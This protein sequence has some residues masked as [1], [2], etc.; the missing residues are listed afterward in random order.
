MAKLSI[1]PYQPDNAEELYEAARESVAE[2]QPFLPWCHPDY[3]IDEARSWI[4]LQVDQFKSGNEYQF[5]IVSN[6]GKFLGGCGLNGIDRENRRANLGYWIRST[7]T[8]RG[9]ATAATRLLA[10]WAFKNTDLNRLEIIVSTMNVASLGV[11]ERAGAVR[12]GTLR[13]RLMLHGVAH[14]AV[15]FSYIR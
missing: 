9:A 1:R 7:E 5:V 14:D 12:E 13:S 6:E 3:V 11:A 10:Q 4:K 2:V 8:R 15:V